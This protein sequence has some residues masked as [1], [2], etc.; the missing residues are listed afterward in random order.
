MRESSNR[1]FTVPGPWPAATSGISIARGRD[2]GAVRVQIRNLGGGNVYLSFADQNVI[3]E[4]GPSAET[5]HLPD[6]EVDVFILAPE[7]KLYAVGSAN[8]IMVSVATSD[9]LPIF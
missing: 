4:S 5:Y 7:Q 6:G 9:A 8:N 2:G 1:T 3:A